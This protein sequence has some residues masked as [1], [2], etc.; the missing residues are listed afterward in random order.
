MQRYIFLVT[1]KD[2]TKTAHS[3][4]SSFLEHPNGVPISKNQW[5][6]ISRGKDYP[7]IYKGV[8]VEKIPIFS[9]TESRKLEEQESQLRTEEVGSFVDGEWS[10]V[11]CKPEEVEGILAENERQMVIAHGKFVQL[12]FDEFGVEIAKKY[13]LDNKE[14][15]LGDAN[16]WRWED[17]K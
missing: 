3:A 2:G 8:T 15:V 7:I 13:L 5:Y 10:F 9:T 6:N 17:V 11:K 1:L 12:G 16:V 4:V 14:I